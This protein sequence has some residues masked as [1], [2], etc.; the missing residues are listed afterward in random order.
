MPGFG[1][2]ISNNTAA[3]FILALDALQV[4]GIGIFDTISDRDDLPGGEGGVTPRINGYIAIVKDADGNGTTKA[5]IYT[6]GDSGNKISGEYV[7]DT[8][9]DAQYGNWSELSTFTSVVEDTTPQLG[10]NLDVNGNSITSA[11]NG[12]IT[13]DPNGTGNV[14]IGNFT[15]DADQSVGDGQDNY[16]LTYDK[17]TQLI[18]LEPSATGGGGTM[19]SFT[20]SATTDTTPTTITNGEDLF[21]ADGTRINCETTADGTVT[22]STT[23]T[24]NQTDA[25]LLARANHTGTQTAATISDFDTEVANNSAVTANTAKVS[26][27]GLVTTHSDVTDAGSGAIITSAERTKLNG[28]EDSADVTDAANVTSSLVAATTISAQDKTTIQGN[29][30][31]DPAGTDNSSPT[32]IT[33]AENA[34]TVTI[35]SS[36]GNNDDI[37]AATTTLAGVMSSSDKTKLNGIASGAEVN[38]DTNITITENASTVTVASST[39]NNDDIQAATTTL[40]GVMSA[41]DK[42][43]LNGIEASADITDAAN[44]AAAGAVMESDFT[45]NGQLVIGGTSGA[46][47]A[48]LTQGSNVTITNGDG[49]I[50]IAANDTNTTYTAGDG[51]DLTGTE[52]SA[53]LKANGGL[54]IES[55]ELAVDL[56]AT[57]ITGT[58]AVSDGGTGATTAA[59]ARTNL[60]V[61]QAGTDNSTNVTLV[62]TPDYITISGQEIT[63]NAI[64]LTTDVTGSLPVANGGTG[65]TTL[66]ST[67]VLVGNGTSGIVTADSVKIISGIL[68]IL[69]KTSSASGTITFHEAANNGSNLT[70][71]NCQPQLSANNTVTLPPSTG[72]LALTSD[73]PVN[74]DDLGDWSSVTPANGDVPQYYLGQYYPAPLGA[75]DGINVTA[76]TPSVQGDPVTEISVGANQ[77]TVQTIYNSNLKIGTSSTDDY[78][79]F[80]G[81]NT[82]DLVVNGGALGVTFQPGSVDFNGADLDAVTDIYT[83][84]IVGRPTPNSDYISFANADEIHL[85]TGAIT[86]LEVNDSGVDIGTLNTDQNIF[87]KTGNNDNDYQGDVVKFGSGTTVQGDLYYYSAGSWTAANASAVATSGG[88]LLGIALGTSPTTNGMLIRGMYTLAYDP[89][90][91]GD[92]LYV[93]TTAGDIQNSA[94]NANNNVVR[95]VG[96]C[97]DSTNGQIWFDPSSDWIEVSA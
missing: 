79:D 12:N 16:V 89:G 38:V 26:A 60:D 91:D 9:W 11:S 70:F 64:D 20:V 67:E 62:G 97:L 6:G 84:G 45:A 10:G 48:T 50:T 71:L 59:D 73:I 52:F 92:E 13:I 82:I 21:F 55:T 87:T 7:A 80:S 90:T 88:Y 35:Q 58:L 22:I 56:G 77:T 54:V 37:Q 44:V 8:D 76:V 95:V 41:T 49:T 96:Y 94:P 83:D 63:R 4:Q 15:F 39:G 23:A 53:D 2:A 1:S 24:T 65:Q 66:A 57:A 75:G 29:L 86:R 46:A 19:S 61:D 69:G 42:T 40:A 85:V 14:L 43:K 32:N 36:T 25:H 68:N 33:V 5:Y 51:L 74:T 30:D 31:V 72:T 27:D 78:I 81:A 93:S 17:D 28:I 18:S 3:S 34:S 47:I